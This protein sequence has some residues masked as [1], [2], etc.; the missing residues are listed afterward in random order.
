[1]LSKKLETTLHNAL[2]LATEKEHD[3]AT[4][5]HLL[6]ALTSDDDARAVMRACG[7]DMT[8]LREDLMSY[9]ETCCDPCAIQWTRGSHGCKCFDRFVFRTGESRGLF[10]RTTGY[11]TF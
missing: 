5:E 11:D 6:Y 1:M 4:L 7:V 8:I 10:S 9:I 3:Y 2:N